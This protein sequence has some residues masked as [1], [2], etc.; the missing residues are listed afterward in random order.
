[1]DLLND[2][3]GGDQGQQ[4]QDFVKRYD[5]GSPW[6]GI[7][8]DEAYQQY[9]AVAPRLSETQF[10]DSAQEA[11]TRLTPEQRLE[12]GRWLQTQSRQ[13]GAAVPDLDRDGI[14][15]RLQDPG[16]LAGATTQLRTQQPGMLD[17]LL[18]GLMGGGGTAGVLGGGG[19]GGGGGMLSSPIAK[20]A[21][22]GIAAMAM[23]KLMGR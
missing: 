11:F 17:S 5:Q 10:R 6:D 19:G 22:G 3:L 4:R 23:S 12:F 21:I 14:D 16:Y 7:D 20:A 9:Q 15:D 18:G 2:L 13:R 8:D 1:M